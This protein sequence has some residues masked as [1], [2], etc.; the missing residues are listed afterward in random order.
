M[1]IIPVS[2]P[3]DLRVAEYRNVPDGVLLR[4][5]GLFVAEGRLVVRQLVTASSLRPHSFLVTEAALASLTDVLATMPDL[6]VYVA[7]HVV[8]NGIVGFNIHRGCLAIGLRPPR[9]ALSDL[10]NKPP[11][12][13]SEEEL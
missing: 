5:K 13:P 12:R 9:M 2:D 4:E 11:D 10:V 6:P 3:D 8:L 1:A 7:P